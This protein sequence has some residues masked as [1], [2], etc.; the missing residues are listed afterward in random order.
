MESLVAQS[1]PASEEAFTYASLLSH[2][3]LSSAPST[4]SLSSALHSLQTDILPRCEASLHS[5]RSALVEE[6]LEAQR[7]AL[8]E[9]QALS[10]LPRQIEE[11]EDEVMTLASSMG[12]LDEWGQQRVP[13]LLRRLTEQRRDLMRADKAVPFVALLARA[14]QLKQDTLRGA[15]DQHGSAKAGLQ[16]LQSLSSLVGQAGQAYAGADA[17]DQGSALMAYLTATRDAALREL[18]EKLEAKLRS[19]LE[20]SGWPP[21]SAE[22]AEARGEAIR[23]ASSTLDSKRVKQAWQR[24]CRLQRVAI[25]AKLISKASYDAQ[26]DAKVGSTDYTPLAPVKVLME[27]LL[28]R[29]AYHFDGDKSTNRLDKPQWYVNH[30]SNLLRSYNSLF[31]ARNGKV[32][33]LCD[34]GGLHKVGPRELVHFVLAAL[35]LKVLAS[36]EELQKK[37]AVLAH[38][39][40]ILLS[41]DSEL[42]QLFHPSSLGKAE[43][44]SDL[45]LGD[46]TTFDAWLE[47]ERTEAQERLQE[48]LE[49]KDAWL[50]SSADMDTEAEEDLS[51]QTWSAISSSSSNNRS[52]HTSDRRGVQKTT[53]SARGLC[54]ILEAISERSR[55]LTLLVQRLGFLAIQ[56]DLLSTYHQ[57]LTR[58]LDAFES[59]SGAFARALPGGIASQDSSSESDM[60]R[61]LRGSSRLLKAFL[62]SLYVVETL[63]RLSEEGHNMQL[64]V[65]LNMDT[66][67]AKMARE[68]RRSWTGKREEV[69]LD[70]ASL[71]ELVRRGMRGGSSLRPL[72]SG[73][74]ARASKNASDEQVTNAD[75]DVWQEARERF[76]KVGNRAS[77]GLVRLV[78]SEVTEA[79]RE[80]TLR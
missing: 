36:K 21:V 79:M 72:A 15:E 1:S 38:T 30:M 29:F 49:D 70:G 10:D 39:V 63:R 20:E 54:Q 58:S 80:Y 7:C 37:P 53:R 73:V 12:L 33:W 51:N 5:S 22:I 45:L 56:D 18:N 25:R 50:I 69:E 9:K 61:G 11:V 78:T 48:I 46:S 16:A 47:G 40:S 17:I 14:E 34:Q 4:S 55:P 59:L 32:T 27:P 62:S 74:G 2:P 43:K 19:A 75:E 52:N 24:L 8:E 65:D 76:E 35:R 42:Q 68:T 41:F 77:K 31:D 6:L 26:S 71:G 3:L 64:N 66:A 28:A 60:V 57:R 13:E 23:S 44:I 67:E